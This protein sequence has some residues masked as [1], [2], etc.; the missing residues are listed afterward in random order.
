MASAFG[1]TA[2]GRDSMLLP[3]L[4]KDLGY[5]TAIVGKLHLNPKTCTRFPSGG[6]FG[7]GFDHQYGFV[8]GMSDYYD[9]HR[10]WSRN[11]ELL[12]EMGY[13]TEL[14]A[15]EAERVV[16]GHARGAHRNQSLFL[17]LSLSAPHTPLQAP[18]D[19][20]LKQRADLDPLVKTYAAMVGAMDDAFGRTTAALRATGMLP[21]TLILF[22]SD[23]GGPI[24]PAACNG[25]L[26]GGKGSPYEGGVRAPAFLYWPPCLGRARRVSRLST[27]MVDVFATL[28]TA[29]SISMAEEQRQKL[30]TRLRKKAPH[31]LALWSGLAAGSGNGGNGASGGG[32]G[33]NEPP[34]F[35]KRLLVLQAS[36][37][38][39]SVIRGR[40]KLVLANE[41]CFGLPSDTSHEEKVAGF[42]ADRWILARQAEQE[43]AAAAASGGGGSGASSGALSAGIPSGRRLRLARA[44]GVALQL[45]DLHNDP[46]EAHDLLLETRPPSP[47]STAASSFRHGVAAGPPHRN[48]T[49][50]AEAML[51]HYLTAARAGRRAIERAV[52]EGRVQRGQVMVLWFCR[53]V[54]FSWTAARWDTARR[55]MCAGRTPR[56]RRQLTALPLLSAATASLNLTSR[57]IFA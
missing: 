25:G 53:Q 28:V 16:R 14:F 36:A 3:S 24:I 55:M 12:R 13:A 8:G 34:E 44:A 27:H 2:I 37:S 43:A 57:L 54:E 11:G 42:P 10:T 31:S 45:Y 1:W 50:L 29:A 19:W 33:G 6:P 5:R 51:G 35:I 40:W 21:S 20:L 9:H 41:R 17:W 48:H 26:R 18:Q 32:G 15:G 30:A 38:S 7:C 39:S 22:M 56:E 47:S 49:A 52:A 23:N 4:L 46:A